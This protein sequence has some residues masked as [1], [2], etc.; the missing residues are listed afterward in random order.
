VVI[1]NL[2]TVSIP[3]Q[4]SETYPILIID[5]DT[6]LPLAILAVLREFFQTIAGWN[7]QIAQFNRGIQ[8]RQFLPRGTANSGWNA[9]TLTRPP[10]QL[11][12][13]VPKVRNHGS[14]VS[15]RVTNVKG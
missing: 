9:T 11:G 7:P 3:I 6:V 13:G 8:D 1:H 15:Q 14:I 4:P 5:P 2:H 10:Q 12:V